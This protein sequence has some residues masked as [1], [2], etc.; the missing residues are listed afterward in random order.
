MQKNSTLFI[1][2]DSTSYSRYIMKNLY[3]NK[4]LFEWVNQHNLY[5]NLK[6]YHEL[7]TKYYKKAI[8]NGRKPSL[9]ILKKI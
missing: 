4:H 8:F 1:A 2:T 3:E 7:E 9:F 6:H 5:L